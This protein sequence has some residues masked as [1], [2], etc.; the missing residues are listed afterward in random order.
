MDLMRELSLRFFL[1]S[2]WLLL[3]AGGAHANALLDLDG[4]GLPDFASVGDWDGDGVRELTDIQ[5]AVDALTDPGLKRI[6]VEA[7]TFIPPAAPARP[8]GLVE[9]PSNSVLECAGTN[10]TILLG[11]PATVKNVN[12]S[13]LS[14]Q[15]HFGGNQNI[16]I[17]NCQIDGG[18]PDAYDSR[19][20]T[21]HGRMGVNLNAVTGGIVRGSFVHHTHHTCLYTKNS[22]NI[23]FENNTLEDCGGYGDINALT[24]KPAIYLFATAGGVM[25]DFVATG[26]V[27]ARSGG[28]ALNTRRDNVIDTVRDIEFINNSVD[29]TPA[30]FA[31][32][33][34]E[35]C[36]SIRGT[37]GILVK[38]NVCRHTAS[39]YIAGSTPGYYGETGGHVDGNRNVVIE[40]LTMT[41]LE[42][43]RGI[44]VGERVNGMLLRRVTISRTPAGLPC[45]SW[46]TPTR[47]LVLQ[48]VSVTDC[49]GAGILQTGPG[50][51]A[52]VAERVRLERVTVNGADVV[53]TADASYQ[54]GIEL[55]GTNDG[56]SLLDVTVRR[57]SLHGVRLG[58]STGPLTNSTLDRVRV[59]GMPSGYLG[60][61]TASS[62]PACNA[63]R[64]GDWAV[65]VNALTGS[66][67]SGGG[68]TE[69]RCRCVGGSWTD[70]TNSV[71]QYGIDLSSG[72]S[73]GNT[74]RDVDFDNLSDSWG[75]RLG[76]AEH[77]TL[78]ANVSAQD[79]G[80]ITTLRQ[81]GAVIVEAGAA[82]VVVTKAACFGM[83][84]GYSCVSG[85]ADSDADGIGDSAD[86]CPYVANANQLDSDGD[87]IG[88]V[89]EGAPPGCGMGGEV[90]LLLAGVGALRR[91]RRPRA[92]RELDPTRA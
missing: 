74:F 77:D 87:G 33:P 13:V 73:H 92:A 39:I 22:T 53:T 71:I 57:F 91:L 78:V 69:N 1:F 25:Q 80:Q 34:P 43:D 26:N 88:N 48:D 23:R 44:V 72:A 15:D 62:L 89:C 75:L 9:L 24:R 59:D 11:L 4:D 17:A 3:V 45:L 31:R 82:N 28:N 55:Q 50:S 90:T 66:S 42:S 10:A 68:S 79:N 20:W 84:P 12:R 14:N 67:C 35:K 18:M 65:V 61:F 37:D 86:N 46:E 30:P 47:G 32:R 8:H 83:A 27:I 58:S 85:L 41:D 60:R 81:R 7:G 54:D 5:A 64:D 49:G 16:T 19:T 70:L 2:T 56:L 36:I 63:A 51:G 40:D 29:N 52:T 6:S 21:A 38:G 76:G